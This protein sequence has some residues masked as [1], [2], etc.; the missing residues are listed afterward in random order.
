MPFNK[1]P[2]FHI[3]IRKPSL[4]EVDLTPSY[5]NGENAGRIRN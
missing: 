1:D 5:I 4:D 2:N 3:L